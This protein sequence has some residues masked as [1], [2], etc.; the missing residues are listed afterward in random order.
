[1][2]LPTYVLII[3]ALLAIF[4]CRKLPDSSMLVELKP[5]NY[6]DEITVDGTVKAVNSVTINSPSRIDGTIIY[7]VENGV[8]VNK[9]DTVCV[10]E[11]KQLDNYY[12]TVLTNLEKA[13]VDYTKSMADLEMN[14]AMLKAELENI[15]A[16][17]SITNLDSVQMQYMTPV[18]R[19][20]KELEIKK[21]EIER[22]KYTRRLDFLK[23]I[24][25]SELRKVKL[26]IK[27]D[28]IRAEFYRSF[29]D[30]MQMTA[31]LSGLALR[32]DSRINDG[33]KVKEGDQ[34]WP[35]LPL[36]SIPDMSEMKVII[37]ASEV[38][39][40]R[41]SVDDTVFYTFDAMPGN[42]AWGKIKKVEPM[43]HPVS[44]GSKIKEFEITASIDSCKTMPE[45][46]LSANCRIILKQVPDTIVVPQLAIFDEDSIKAVYI[47]H[48]HRFRKQEVILGPSSPKEAVIVAGLKGNE[49]LS[50]VKPLRS[51]ISSVAL[52]NDSIRKEF[53]KPKQDT[54]PISA[55]STAMGM[56]NQVVVV[57]K[58]N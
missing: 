17:T 21:A 26:Q 52:L 35:G 11:N 46:G 34:V 7:L 32:E 42:M 24:N 1:M 40:K 22:G 43:G 45:P 38:D 8:H 5:S 3:I 15:D 39:Y 54:I 31:S 20:I 4:S 49:K 58:M 37:M 33:A 53:N 27:Q 16:Q 51:Q 41:I 50:L 12:E 2:K 19:K 57:K 47:L 9:G 55:D 56:Q 29:Y 48:G 30:D 25:E 23:R 14:Y 28:S 6:T 44:R 18:Q 10:M 13:R 36:V